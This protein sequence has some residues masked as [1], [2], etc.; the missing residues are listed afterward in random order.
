MSNKKRGIRPN[1]GQ[2]KKTTPDN[3]TSGV[4]VQN[5][6]LQPVDRTSKD[7]QGFRM[8]QKLAEFIHNPSRIR[9]LDLMEEAMLDTYLT[10]IVS[11][12]LRMVR[13]KPL[14]IVD[15]DGEHLEEFDKFLRSRKFRR[16]RKLIF[17]VHMYG[18][19]GV[20]FLPGKFAYDIIPRKHIKPHL[21]RVTW[22]QLGNE[23]VDYKDAWNFWVM[24]SD[25][26]DNNFGL[27][28]KAIPW[29]IYKR[30][31]IGDYAQFIEQFGQPVK[32]A[33]YSAY[34]DNTR[35]QLE[36]MMKKAGSS[37][38][39]MIPKEA[40]FDI[41]DGKNSNANG[42]LQKNF[43][44]ELCNNELDVLILGSTET[45]TSSDR[46]GY[47]LGKVHQSQTF[48]IVQDDMDNEIEALND[49]HFINILRTYGYNIPEDAE[50]E[51][52]EDADL[53]WLKEKIG[54]DSEVADIVDV[55]EDYFY[56]TYN[57]PRPQ[58]GDKIAGKRGTPKEIIQPDN[59]NKPNPA[60]PDPNPTPEPEETP[61][62]EPKK[63]PTTKEAK[64]P[65][66]AFFNSIKSMLKDFF[67]GASI[68]GHLTNKINTYYES[69]CAVCGIDHNVPVAIS[70]KALEQLTLE[71]A[72]ELFAGRL[73]DG[74]IPSSLYNS[75]A[76]KLMQGLTEGLG[77]FGFDYEDS[78]NE[79]YAYLQHNIHAFSAA[80][81]LTE[82]LH[83]RSLLTDADGKQRSF[84]AFRNAV[85]DAGYQFNVNYLE[86]EYLNTV[87]ASQS[88]A[89][90]SAFTDDELI[91]ISTVGDERVRPEHKILDK[92][93][94][95]KSD[96]IWQR[97]TPPFDWRCRCIIIPG[98]EANIKDV[99]KGQLIKDA[100]VPKSFQRNPATDKVVFDNGH[101][102]YK[103]SGRKLKELTAESNY[104][105]QSI[106]TIYANNYFDEAKTLESSFAAN[107]WWTNRAG[108]LRG[109]IDVKDVSGNTIRFPNKFRV[110][111]LEQNN[112]NRF[113]H[114][115]NLE[116]IVSNPDEV[117]S[118]KERGVL[119]K[120]YIK[121]YE[122]MPQAVR[123]EGTDAFTMY[124]F[125]RKDGS[126]NI[127]S[128]GRARRGAL[129]YRKN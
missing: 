26:D 43:I 66:K 17:N 34:D 76:G 58:K 115:S 118:Y 32:I 73:P 10:G 100:K 72:K 65:P 61:V 77:G 45:T 116:D 105:M 18:I 60:N 92:F 113:K 126:V 124:K 101:P 27:L 80:K 46:G 103:A 85:T 89:A 106:E 78:R 93:T 122:D 84:T 53:S 67:T 129:L 30:G 13:N 114:L 87:A 68:T 88:A 70:D 37:L 63:D 8:A 42:D 38:S 64:T 110:H 22:E 108:S 117:W 125:A 39:M 98:V 107:E 71:I 23:G 11:K 3:D 112:D 91:Q 21:G 2:T 20:E 121:Y 127:E 109:Y 102:Y 96:P 59:P 35:I 44:K 69:S 16:L 7:I 41:K 12:R 94:A 24:E 90:F 15:K 86:T 28:L 33:K 74:S 29:I 31:A 54:V 57:I 14:R 50:F 47:A 119:Q 83:F 55:P 19:G 82:L 97:L 48:E 40:E 111:V 81:S 120:V 95:R 9:L 56:D 99:D 75:S 49:D 4:V 104:G 79:L 6:V 128:I 62:T 51:H 25:E 52:V 5:V 36:N 123:V 1:A